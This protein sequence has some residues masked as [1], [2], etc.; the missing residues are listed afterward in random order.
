MASKLSIWSYQES[1]TLRIRPLRRFAATEIWTSERNP[2]SSTYLLIRQTQES[3][4]QSAETEVSEV[5]N[6]LWIHGD[7]D[8]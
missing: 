4:S 7:L 6:S 8:R 1:L 5:P 2:V 3:F